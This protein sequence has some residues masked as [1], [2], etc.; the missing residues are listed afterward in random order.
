MSYIMK[1]AK[2]LAGNRK[3]AV[4]QFLRQ[5]TKAGTEIKVFNRGKGIFE[6]VVTKAN[7]DTY[8][9][10]FSKKEGL[11]EVKAL[12]ARGEWKMETIDPKTD[13]FKA[14][15]IWTLNAK[16][17][18][19]KKSCYSFRSDSPLSKNGPDLQVNGFYNYLV[20]QDPNMSL[21]QLKLLLKA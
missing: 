4:G 21:K 14:N 8:T 9:S 18:R 17:I 5:M 6:K 3:M 20:R 12:N 10:L 2:T 13:F 16:G 11:K 1:L 7:G 19:G 15:A